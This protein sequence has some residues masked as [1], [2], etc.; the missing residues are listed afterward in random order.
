MKKRIA[1]FILAETLCLGLTACGSRSAITT[2]SSSE[3]SYGSLPSSRESTFRQSEP[4]PPSEA[5]AVI[6]PEPKD[7]IPLE[8]EEYI[9]EESEEPF[10]LTYLEDDVQVD[11]ALSP[12]DAEEI[13]N[14]LQYLSLN[15]PEM[16]IQCTSCGGSGRR[17]T[18]C[19]YCGGSGQRVLSE[20]TAF[21]ASVPC[22]ACRDGYPSR[23]DCTFGLME[24]PNYAE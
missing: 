22:S 17:S 13:E 21:V 4:E 23:D 24:N 5:D 10:T 20:V 3:S 12:D 6:A 18:P 8:P 9:S 1:A 14:E 2:P 15:R 7:D 19:E 16:L 11:M